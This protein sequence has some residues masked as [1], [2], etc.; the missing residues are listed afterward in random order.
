M[1]FQVFIHANGVIP[2]PQST[3]LLLIRV[4]IWFDIVTFILSVLYVVASFKLEKQLKTATLSC[5]PHYSILKFLWAQKT[6][7]ARHINMH[8]EN[9]GEKRRERR[10]RKK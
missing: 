3:E 8:E 2:A 7:A 1:V 4:S 5:K 6:T 10:K 9:K